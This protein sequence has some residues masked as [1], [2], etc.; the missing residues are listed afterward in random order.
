MAAG[1][2]TASCAVVVVVALCGVV[3]ITEA[4]RMVG[5]RS[6]VKDVASN[7][8]VQELGRFSVEEYKRS[9]GKGR[10]EARGLVFS[11]VVAAE[12]QVVS[13]L[14]YYLKV[15]AITQDGERRLFDSVVVVKPWERSKQLV[16]FAP[17]ATKNYLV[18]Q[19]EYKS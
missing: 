1:F 4:E 5:G 9:M 17:S 3:A 12:K 16:G 13:G 10:R 7:E 19:K 18:M 11:E 15:A 6:E 14:K 2:R 8:E